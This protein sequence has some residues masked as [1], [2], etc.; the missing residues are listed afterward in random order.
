[1]VK[2]S[3]AAQRKAAYLVRVNA[4]AIIDFLVDHLMS[5]EPDEGSVTGA[6]R[7]GLD[8]WDSQQPQGKKLVDASD[9]TECT[10]APNGSKPLDG[11][12]DAGASADMSDL[13][14]RAVRQQQQLQSAVDGIT[15]CAETP[16]PMVEPASTSLQSPVLR[17]PGGSDQHLFIMRHGERQ[18]DVDPSWIKSAGR[19]YDPPLTEP[20]IAAARKVGAELALLCAGVS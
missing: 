16:I 20:G 15:Q 13:M 3:D 8:L 4:P 19:P 14:E 7:Q 6:L 12:H 2:V 11:A 10:G 17:P 5:L 9:G 18:D 1:M